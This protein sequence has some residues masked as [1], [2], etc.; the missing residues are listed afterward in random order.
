ML[1]FK[2]K[3]QGL[4]ELAPHSSV[5]VLFTQVFSRCMVQRA[6]TIKYIILFVE[7]E[8]L[9]AI[10]VVDQPLGV[11][12]VPEAAKELIHFEQAPVLLVLLLHYGLEI[13]HGPVAYKHLDL[14]GKL[15]SQVCGGNAT[16]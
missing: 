10:F 4:V 13:A 11:I 5:I 9:K 15:V 6:E 12:N 3:H 2:D 1:S 8:Y 14:F 16:N 7:A